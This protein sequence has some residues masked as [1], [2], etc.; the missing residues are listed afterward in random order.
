MESE[1]KQFL[2]KVLTFFKGTNKTSWGKSEMMDKLKD[3]YIE[4]LE[5]KEKA[6]SQYAPPYPVNASAVQK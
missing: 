6:G 5:E 2:Q 1:V 4:F 3:L